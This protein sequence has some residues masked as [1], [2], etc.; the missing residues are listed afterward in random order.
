MSGIGTVTRG[1]EEWD[2]LGMGVGAGEGEGGELHHPGYPPVGKPSPAGT[3]AEAP[4]PLWRWPYSAS[5][6]NT[7]DA[8]I[9]LGFRIRAIASRTALPSGPSLVRIA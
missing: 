4:I 7:S 2:P 5:P 6:A 1:T 9:S 8:L 3:G